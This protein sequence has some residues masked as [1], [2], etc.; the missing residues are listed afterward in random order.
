MAGELDDLLARVLGAVEKAVKAGGRIIAPD[1]E[2]ST[3]SRGDDLHNIMVGKLKKDTE[4]HVY[5]VDVYPAEANQEYY[6]NVAL[7]S[8]RREWIKRMERFAAMTEGGYA[9]PLSRA[10]LEGLLV[11]LRQWQSLQARRQPNVAA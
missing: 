6:K 11:T 8:L 4:E 7:E 9:F 3:I 1:I 10:A 5:L 2:E